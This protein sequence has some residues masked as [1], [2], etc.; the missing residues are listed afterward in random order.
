MVAESYSEST[1]RLIWDAYK[2][3]TIVSSQDIHLENE[4][5]VNIYHYNID[6]KKLEF[7]K[8]NLKVTDGYIEFEIEHCSE[9]FVT[10][11]TIGNVQKQE[12]SYNLSTIFAIIEFRV[13]FSPS[14]IISPLSILIGVLKYLWLKFMF[15]KISLPFS[16]LFIQT[17]SISVF[18]L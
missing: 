4:S 6:N 12:T 11:S 1:F 15:F 13:A 14:R 9:Y 16:W 8:D 5:T 7:I 2:V 10:M 18:P 17:T 3:K